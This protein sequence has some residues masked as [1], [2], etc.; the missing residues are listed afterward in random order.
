MDTYDIILAAVKFFSIA[1]AC[2]FGALGII[3]DVKDENKKITPWGRVA[4]L[5]VIISALLSTASQALEVYKAKID[6]A[7]ELQKSFEEAKRANDQLFEIKRNLERIDINQVGIDFSL[8]FSI[9]DPMFDNYKKQIEKAYDYLRVEAEKAKKRLIENPADRIYLLR[10]KDRD[11]LT[12]F[13]G[14][15]YWPTSHADGKDLFV[16]LGALLQLKNPRFIDPRDEL[17]FSLAAPFSKSSNHYYDLAKL[18][19]DTKLQRISLHI[20]GARE[21]SPIQVSQAFLSLV[22]F[23]GADVLFQPDIDVNYAP[24]A[25]LGG[26]RMKFGS[27]QRS[28]I[29][30]KSIKTTVSDGNP[31]F[32]FK[33]VSR[34]YNYG[35]TANNKVERDAPQAAQP[36]APN[37]SP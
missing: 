22:D 5:G 9:N 4:I 23:E 34:W 13:P 32:T 30:E 1:A 16:G 11:F 6:Q 35:E 19:Y 12:I 18:T 24:S 2:V 3:H 31:T 21:L 27:N 15:T 26:F 7:E 25:T 28:L 36:L 14:S 20:E 10:T 33:L 8:F 37:P 17:M 29:A